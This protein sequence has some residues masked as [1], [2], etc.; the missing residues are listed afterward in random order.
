MATRYVNGAIADGEVDLAVVA[1]N[2][3]QALWQTVGE[4][5]DVL[6]A[7]SPQQI[8]EHPCLV[9][10]A[11][12]VWDAARAF[13]GLCGCQPLRLLLI[14]V[15]GFLAERGIVAQARRSTGAL[16]VADRGSDRADMVSTLCGPEPNR[17]TILAAIE[18][19][20]YLGHALGSSTFYEALLDELEIPGETGRLLPRLSSV[21]HLGIPQIVAAFRAGE[22]AIE[23]W[24]DP[25][26]GS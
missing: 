13:D 12:R 14:D 5:G 16:E 11:D 17:Q 21:G 18:R 20:E 24:I 22:R 3:A 4:A 19:L 6:A 26:A 23:G 10:L 25:S 15:E 7:G 2:F 1:Q 9:R 8:A